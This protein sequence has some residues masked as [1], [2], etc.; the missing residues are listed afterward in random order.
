MFK[1]IIMVVLLSLVAALGSLLYYYD[2]P[3]SAEFQ[4]YLI[5]TSAAR[6]IIILILAF[7]I[8]YAL[9]SLLFWL[10]NSP[11]RLVAKR[12][13]VRSEE[14]YN[15]LTRGFSALASGDIAKA[16]KYSD[17]AQKTLPNQ[18]LVNLLKAQVAVVGEDQENAEKYYR[19]LASN[20]DANFLGYRGL[21]SH[22]PNPEK[23]AE[24]AEEL[25]RKNPKSAWAAEALIDLSFK[26]AAWDKLEKFL[27]K[28]EANRAIPKEVLKEKF[29]VFYYMKSKIAAAEAR[30]EDAE[31]LAERSL[32]Y[33][34]NFVPAAIFL[35]EL[36]IKH[37][38][39][40]KAKRIVEE[41]WRI[42][43][44]PML[45]ASY[46]EALSA[47]QE[48]KI[49][50][51]TKLYQTSPD[52]AESVAY[53]ANALIESGQMEEAKQILEH[54]LGIRSTRKLCAIM[55]RIDDKTLWQNKMENAREDKCWYCALTGA[56]Y[57][58][59]QLY[60]DSGKLNTINWGYPS[61]TP[62][63]FLPKNNF[64]LI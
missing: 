37:D 34:N 2:F 27:K 35:A 19:L 54:G 64:E 32:K 62:P 24:I 55:S 38:E 53:Y 8:F 52:D 63:Q 56:R 15:N 58:N 39:Y 47:L 43:P 4:S 13:T 9:I 45:A 18:P 57:Y 51:I 16:Q 49:K 50:K 22:A 17:K 36:F 5:E 59:W 40:K 14:A 7:I 1:L 28:A 6:V 46:D 11:K 61:E 41:T 42:C 26:N 29:A 23:A 10:K 31:W 60:S 21:I 20:E 48:S 25:L 3:I 44:H 30:I 33:K 12:R